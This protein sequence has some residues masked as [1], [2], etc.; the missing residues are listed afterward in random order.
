MVAV[1]ADRFA[2]VLVQIVVFCNSVK[3]VSIC[4]SFHRA[5]SCF[6]NHKRKTK[7][8]I[9][10][11]T[12]VTNGVKD[13]CLVPFSNHPSITKMPSGNTNSILSFILA[14]THC[15]LGNVELFSIDLN[16]SKVFSGKMGRYFYRPVL[17]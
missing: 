7:G 17:K 3:P 5:R 1:K 8:V 11:L 12:T 4:G 14:V 6:T 10:K 9:V 15:P 2:K 16:H 13:H